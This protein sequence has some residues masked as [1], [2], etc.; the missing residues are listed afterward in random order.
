[1]EID[2]MQ[3]HKIENQQ[4]A[5]IWR[6]KLLISDTLWFPLPPSEVLYTIYCSLWRVIY[7]V[8]LLGT[9]CFFHVFKGVQWTILIPAVKFTFLWKFSIKQVMSERFLSVCA[10]NYLVTR[11]PDIANNKIMYNRSALLML[12]KY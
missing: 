8:Y 12:N 1:M 6:W 9:L 3:N 7:H 10:I 2:Q 5:Y 4:Q 11:Q